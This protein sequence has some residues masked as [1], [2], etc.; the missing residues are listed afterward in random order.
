MKAGVDPR[1]RDAKIVA[2]C[3]R[4]VAHFGL[5]SR[6][7]KT[8][9]K[10]RASVI[11]SRVLCLSLVVAGGVS[12]Q[13]RSSAPRQAVEQDPG[14]LILPTQPL[15]VPDGND[16]VIK[17]PNGQISLTMKIKN[18]MYIQVNGLVAPVTY[19]Q[20][21]ER[22]SPLVEAD[23]REAL[24]QS[25]VRS[26][27]KLETD[28]HEEFLLKEIV[29]EAGYYSMWIP[30][31]E[32]LWNRLRAVKDLP[33]PM[34]L[35]AVTTDPDELDRVAQQS[36]KINDLIVAGQAKDSTDGFSGLRRMGITPEWL[37]ALE[38][39]LG[40]KADGSLVKVGVTDTGITY[41][42]PS[43]LD[44]AGKSRI[45]YMKDFT[46]EGK[47]Y[48]P[49]TA[50]FS[51]RL[52]TAAE[53]NQI[54]IAQSKLLFVEDVSAHVNIVATTPPADGSNLL[55]LP[56]GAA[57]EVPVEVR[58]AVA[59]GA[60]VRLGFLAEVAL[61]TAFDLNRNQ[62]NDDLLGL[63]LVAPPGSREPAESKVYIALD[64]VGRLT[65]AGAIT[66][67]ERLELG[68]AVPLRDF[69][70]SG[71]V[72][73]SYAEKF[74]LAFETMKLKN[75][76]GQDVDTIAVGIVGYD[77]GLHGS[78]VAGI[79]G[80]RKTLLNDDEL[81]LARGVAP[82]AQLLSGRV[83]GN[84]RGCSATNAILDL[85]L[86][87]K[88]DV[89]NMSLGA[90]SNMNDG[91]DTQSLLIDRLSQITNTQFVISAG[92][93][94][95]GLQTIGSPSS[96]RHA[97]SVAASASTDIMGRQ[98]QIAIPTADGKDE[99]F[100]MGFSS[101]GP[102]GNGGFKP[103]ITAP[104]TQLSA[105]SLNKAG[106]AGTGVMQ[107]TSMSAPAVAGAYAML[108]D[109]A[110]RYNK[111]HP[112][113]Q[114]P[115][116][117]RILR[118]VLLGSAKPFDIKTFDPKTNKVTEGQ[119]TWIDQGT[120]IVDLPAAWEALKALG[121]KHVPTGITIN[122]KA[123]EPVYEVRTLMT[124]RYGKVYDGKPVEGNSV[125]SYGAG[126]WIDA[127]NPRPLYTVGIARR[128]PLT[129]DGMLTANEQGDAYAQLVSSA[130][131]FKL[132]TEIHGSSVEWLK[133]NT[134][135]TANS[136]EANL[137]ES[138]AAGDKLTLVGQGAL[139]AA[140]VSGT[141][142]SVIYVC[143][144]R[145]K[146]ARLP[147]GDHGALVRAYRQTADGRIMEN[148]PSFI[149]PIYLSIPHESLTAGKAYTVTQS[150]VKALGISRNYVEVPADISSLRVTL[151]V[152]KASVDP[153]GQAQN[154][155]GVYLNAYAG[156]NVI[157]PPELLDAVAY[158][159]TGPAYTV[160]PDDEALSKFVGEIFEPRPG[161]WDLHVEGLSRY[162]K[163]TYQ[164][165]VDYVKA[166]AQQKEVN[167]GIEALNGSL[168]VE[169]KE[170]SVP[171][172]VSP[173]R[174]S[175]VLDQA[176]Q[177]VQPIV[178]DGETIEVANAAGQLLRRYPVGVTQVAV[179]TAGAS[180]SD[181][182]LGV[183][184]CALNGSAC[185]L[186]ASSGG[187]TD[188]EQATFIPKANRAYIFLVDGYRVLDGQTRF[189]LT[190]SITFAQGAVGTVSAS[191]LGS[192]QFWNVTYR[193]DK[194]DPF[195]Q[196]EIFTNDPS[197][198]VRGRIRVASDDLT[199][200]VIPVQVRLR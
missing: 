73:Q 184:E 137:C 60:S 16:G 153:F 68:K 123:I 38:Q 112:E 171:K 59:E 90:L 149:I 54:G 33:V 101:R 124:N 100:V 146:I 28:M 5:F 98:S 181:L 120:G 189:Q 143:I 34:T 138:I 141:A 78:H 79:I 19:G 96:A 93:S 18:R 162:P 61:G 48:F 125:V 165:R 43:F 170:G 26:L 45:V 57:L 12:C 133:V 37:Q 136:G 186:V 148:V 52:G 86:E 95:P 67:Q 6:I 82:N 195:F 20:F 177:T 178:K 1:V 3:S 58:R 180:G 74:G 53:A 151:S 14:G 55:T 89:V 185:V 164:L 163:S 128:L 169:I 111:K 198:E 7:G 161:I 99:D 9:Q 8:V 144:D 87:A 166:E 179:A 194:N 35:E 88:A 134:L 66:L 41:N 129:A 155:S 127:S 147:K 69:N 76:A 49:N 70:R 131:F 11:F 24:R 71:D 104:G 160:G 172:N 192:E 94:G 2:F 156:N 47:V 64:P 122:N 83:C 168:V 154:C 183:Q 40:E 187:P 118:K 63:L 135:A 30:Y 193:M 107:G 114:L 199:L 21:L 44:A 113:A 110:R 109:A 103:N 22:G 157:N 200:A 56:K 119:Y 173:E 65:K 175:Y 13:K 182:D 121:A 36:K 176:V 25:L 32:A 46:Q 77:S 62:K 10:Q 23:V 97:I 31:E 105:I 116:D 29:P 130:E 191:P 159:C 39:E 139:D 188:E 190:E 150:Q 27:H 4:G 91:Y 50:K 92:N 106:R 17:W 15:P 84:T 81:T 42:H 108:L 117:N 102:L 115:T 167:G 145:E 140:S 80:G 158:N 197:Y 142:E 132:H 196:S 51:V 75:S 174:S 72:A 126:L 85:A 152:N